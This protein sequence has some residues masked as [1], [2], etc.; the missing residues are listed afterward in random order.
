M[1][2]FEDAVNGFMDGTQG[3]EKSTEQAIKKGVGTAAV[4][5]TSVASAAAAG[6][7]TLTGYAGVASAVSTMGLGGATTAIAGAMGTNVAGA[8]ATAV[9]TYAVGG[10]V[11]MGA[12]LV[13]GVAATGYGVYKALNWLGKQFSES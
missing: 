13:G 4:V 5:G 9:V 12:I 10:P 6:A 8:A 7:G 1:D 3:K 11:V 2:L